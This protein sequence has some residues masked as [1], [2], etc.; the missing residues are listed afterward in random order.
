[1]CRRPNG[2][3]LA[4]PSRDS[5]N[6]SVVVVLLLRLALSLAIP[7]ESAE[8][9]DVVLA[10]RQSIDVGRA[11]ASGALVVVRGH[12]SSSPSDSVF[13]H[14]ENIGL[15]LRFVLVRLTALDHFE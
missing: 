5:P 7:A 8:K 10:L 13:R 3:L 12:V 14:A 11:A 15:E 4:I 1:M 6:E 9:V 2:G